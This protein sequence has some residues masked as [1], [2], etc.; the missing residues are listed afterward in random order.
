MVEFRRSTNPNWFVVSDGR[1][2][3]FV[4]KDCLEE[5]KN[6]IERS[7]S[8]QSHALFVD[9]GKTIGFGGGHVHAYDHKV[10]IHPDDYSGT[11]EGDVSISK[12]EAYDLARQ[13]EREAERQSRIREGFDELKK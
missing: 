1:K 8:Y 13:I 7:A 3:V 6:A 12:E 2:N 4:R 11:N 9:T 5:F 10:D